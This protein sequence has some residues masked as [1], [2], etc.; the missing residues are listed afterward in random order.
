MRSN[1]FTTTYTKTSIVTEHQAATEQSIYSQTPEPGYLAERNNNQYPSIPGPGPA[2]TG[3]V[4]G[5]ALGTCFLFVLI[6][7]LI[8]VGI[9]TGIGLLGRPTK[10]NRDTDPEVVTIYEPFESQPPETSR[11]SLPAR[12]TAAAGGIIRS[13]R[14]TSINIATGLKRD[15]SS[16]GS[17]GR[18]T[19]L[20]H[21]MDEEAAVG[22]NTEGVGIKVDDSFLHQ[23]R[24]MAVLP[25]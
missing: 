24:T 11:S 2:G 7:W 10:E 4:Y 23:R 25:A 9:R 12:G 14:R 15:I 13:A 8:V 20:P 21:P 1:A 6:G 16:M 3:E 22:G 19:S 17:I 5:L 18:R